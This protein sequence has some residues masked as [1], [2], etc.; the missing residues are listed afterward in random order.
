MIKHTRNLICLIVILSSFLS[1][2]SIPDAYKTMN[3]TAS[4]NSFNKIKSIEEIE[5]PSGKLL[6]A[7]QGW[8]GPG[9]ELVLQK[10]T[11]SG[12]GARTRTRRIFN[13]YET[14]GAAAK[15]YVYLPD[16]SL[17]GWASGN[18]FYFTL[19]DHLG[20]IIA[21][22]DQN[23]NI[24][25]Q[26]SYDAWG[27]RRDPA[28]WNYA[29]NLPAPPTT[30]GFTGH[31]HLDDFK[32]INMRGRM[33]DPVLGRFLSPDIIV[34]APENSQSYNR[35]SYC[36]NNPLRYTDPS[37]WVL[38]PLDDE[39]E[40]DRLGNVK[41]VKENKQNDII[42]SI[43]ENGDRMQNVVFNH[44]T[45]EKAYSQNYETE[46]GW[47]SYDILRVRG[48][49]NATRL[50]EFL[51]ENTN[52]EFSHAKMGIEGDKGLNYL[53]TSHSENSEAGMPY[54]IDRQ[55]RFGYTA[56]EFNHTHPRN[57][58]FPSGSF[59]YRKEKAGEWGDVG[60]AR[61]VSAIFGDKVKY[62]IFIP[63]ESTYIPFNSKTRR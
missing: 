51:A 12:V 28:T 49:A 35:Y 15:S 5:H 8:Y 36:L 43:D 29:T 10:I 48:D 3:Q 52:V 6:Y 23:G 1:A 55:L 45:I 17:V 30:K 32:L 34:Q 56:R 57:T 25:Q 42:Y 2:F 24:Q 59:D 26:L 46:G 54:L 9:E 40:V 44:G 22:L 14:E 61:D 60:F 58:P 13:A 39:W 33:Y 62:N 37:G 47:K 41:W 21:I 11:T 16:G 20:S 31:E 4:Y 19:R 53:T 38:K 50:F 27:R 18:N 63:K 7:W